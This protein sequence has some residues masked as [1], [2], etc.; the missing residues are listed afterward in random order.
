M[1]KKALLFDFDGVL[2]DTFNFCY[3]II[4]TYDPLLTK[5]E[6]RSRFLGN[7]NSHRV[8]RNLNRKRD[9]NFFALYT[10]RLLETA[11]DKEVD[12][13]V[14]TLSTKYILFIVS[15]TNTEPIVKFLKMHRLDYCFKAVYGNDIHVSKVEK[16]KMILKKYHLNPSSCLFITDTVGDIKEA[17]RCDIRSVAVSWGFHSKRTLTEGKPF[18]LVHS[19]K[20]L[21]RV[22]ERTL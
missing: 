14:R 3:D 5:K 11:L 10:P 22:I 1:A 15:S 12:L 6:Y 4:K 21:T 20:G 17:R 18:A 7:I 8:I 9:F 13:V 2:A 16:I 19:V